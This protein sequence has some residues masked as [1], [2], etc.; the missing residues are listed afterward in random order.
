MM[1]NRN[2][3]SEGN[4]SRLNIHQRSK[5]QRGYPPK[6]PLFLLDM[7]FARPSTSGPARA[8]PIKVATKEDRFEAPTAVMEKLYG[9]AEKICES[10]IE[11][12]TS[13]EMQVVNSRVAQETIGE[14][15]K[16]NGRMR[17]RQKDVLSQYPS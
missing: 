14:P 6:I 9:G 5:G 3:G 15:R 11:M 13:Q 4:V 16:K 7:N 1:G 10:V 8:V 2:S 12:S 17:V